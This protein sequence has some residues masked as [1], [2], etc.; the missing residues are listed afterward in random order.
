MAT[1]ADL[2]LKFWTPATI[3][4]GRSCGKNTLRPPRRIQPFDDGDRLDR[5]ASKAD[6]TATE[7]IAAETATQPSA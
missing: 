3:S 5:G 6:A 4:A 7:S 2:R 1:T